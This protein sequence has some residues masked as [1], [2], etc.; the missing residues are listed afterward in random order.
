MRLIPINCARPGMILGKTIY[1]AREHRLLNVG[2]TLSEF[3]IKKIFDLRISGIYI[4]DDISKDIEVKNVINDELRIKAINSIKNMFIINN[5]TQ[6][7]ENFR[8]INDLI[9]NIIEEILNNKDGILSIV[10][11]KIFDEYTY[12]HSVNVAV[13]SIVMGVGLKLSDED[14]RYLGLGA[15][16]HDFGKCFIDKNILNK[17][18]KL[19]DAEFEIMKSHPR[20]GYDFLVDR[21]NLSAHSS[22]CIL[23]HHTKWDGTGYPFK[24]NGDKF[25]GEDIIHI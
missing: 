19:T 12:Y 6:L 9:K 4:D 7:D 21:L 22:M 8:S 5:K 10:D 1:D 13:L 2:V 23:Q 24:L 17:N 11:L 20:A 3:Y 14:L 25:I 15:I 16:L 18:G